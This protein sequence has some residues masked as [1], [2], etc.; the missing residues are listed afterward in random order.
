[1][2]G[3]GPEWLD[4]IGPPIALSR[5]SIRNTRT[6][7]TRRSPAHSSARNAGTARRYGGYEPSHRNVPIRFRSLPTHDVRP[8]IVGRFDAARGVAEERRYRAL[9]E[10]GQGAHGED[11]IHG[12]Q[13]D[14]GEIADH[15]SRGD[16]LPRQRC[17][18]T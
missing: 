5:A 16:A 17:G 7:G 13:G 11:R 15:R 18:A 10:V 12:S 14:P 6:K 9:R 1:M 8:R 3:T 4:A 2:D